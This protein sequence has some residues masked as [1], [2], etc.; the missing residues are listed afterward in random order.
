MGPGLSLL[1][2]YWMQNW[3]DYS[4]CIWTDIHTVPDRIWSNPVPIQIIGCFPPWECVLTSRKKSK[5]CERCPTILFDKECIYWKQELWFSPINSP[6]FCLHTFL[7]HQNSMWQSY[8]TLKKPIFGCAKTNSRERL[9]FVI[10]SFLNLT[11]ISHFPLNKIP[12]NI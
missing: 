7:K 5:N 9:K 3:T 8:N 6:A 2:L 4:I 10:T 11:T 1:W 12:T